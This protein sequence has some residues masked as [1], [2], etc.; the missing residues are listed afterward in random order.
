VITWR[1]PSRPFDGQH[2]K[3]TIVDGARMIA[4]G[5]N[6]GDA[7]SHL[8]EEEERAWRDTD[9]YVTG[10]AVAAARDLFARVWNDQIATRELPY[11]PIPEETSAPP[12]EGPGS[13]PVAVVDHR[14]GLDE[15]VLLS[16]LIAFD[17]ARTTIDIENAYFV[18]MPP[19]EAALLAA[20]SR[21]VR[22]RILTNSADSCDEPIVAYAIL[23]SLD[24]LRDAGAEIYLKQGQTLHGK[25]HMI[26]GVFSAIGSYNLHP[27]SYRL[28]EEVMLYVRGQATAKALL[29][30]FELDLRAAK[31]VEGP[32]DL[33][34]PRSPI[35]ALAFRFFL[36]QL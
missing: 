25:F 19:V 20:L 30:V 12:F 22:V 6:I 34:P 8:N 35:G 1:N 2:R 4:G 36:D 28:E 5:R 33:V 27:R 31:A 21:G 16:T 10:P 26:D 11:E 18:R 29:E 17:A 9:M 23:R 3:L 7:Y 13:A 14:P 32:E 24:V 15:H